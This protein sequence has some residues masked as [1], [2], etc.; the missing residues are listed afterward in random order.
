MYSSVVPSYSTV[1]RIRVVNH[2]I[3]HMLAMVMF[4]IIYLNLMGLNCCHNVELPQT[5]TKLISKINVNKL[6]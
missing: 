2:P 4:S 3:L 5:L 1:C 6:L